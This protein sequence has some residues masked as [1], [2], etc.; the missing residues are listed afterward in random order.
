MKKLPPWP[1]AALLPLLLALLLLF[2]ACAG[3]DDLLTDSVN[4]TAVISS[5]DTDVT[6]LDPSPPPDADDDGSFADAV[7]DMGI[8]EGLGRASV[9]PGY[10]TMYE[11]FVYSFYD[12]D[13]DGI[14]DLAGL[15]S[16]LDYISELGF[17]GIW[18]MPIMP[19]TTYHKYDVVDYYDIDPE[20]GTLDDFKA[21]IAACDERG[22]RVIIDL[23]INHTSSEHPLFI[24]A[25][26]YLTGLGAAEPDL[27]ACPAV[28]FYHFNRE[29]VGKSYPVPGTEDWYYEAPFWSGMPDLN[30]GSAAVRDEIENITRFWLDLGVAGFRIDAAKEFVSGD[31]AAN[32]EILRWFNDMLKMVRPDAYIVAEVWDQ[33]PVYAAYYESGI[34]SVFNFAFAGPSGTIKSTADGSRPA[35][36]FG[37]SLAYLDELFGPHNPDYI[38]APFYSNHDLDRAAGYYTGEHAAAQTKLALAL[39]LLMSGNSFTYYGDELG[40]VGAGRDENKRV[41]MPWV[42]DPAAPGMCVGPADRQDFDMLYPSLERQIEDPYSIYNYFKNAVIVRRAFP[43][44]IHGRSQNLDTIANSTLAAFVKYDGDDSCV[45]LANLSPNETS[46]DT[47]ALNTELTTLV[48]TPVSDIA[49]LLVTDDSS[50]ICTAGTLTLPGHGIV[51]LK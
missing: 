14:G 36:N 39:N 1:S 22:I 32:V 13:G 34:D 30:L 21:F 4:Y 17:D 23:V 7:Y 2:N 26:E 19:S 28:E 18:L 16:Q 6:F 44:I 3:D 31:H 43:E 47:A 33:A 15:T 40:M 9:R 12:S 38:D 42:D 27:A 10:G 8:N 51:V 41:A 46:I 11:V 35:E 25:C 48:S 24:E 45:I 37:K 20:Y 50:V 5:S 29:R 49:A